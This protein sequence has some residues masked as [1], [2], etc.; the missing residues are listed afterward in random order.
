MLSDEKKKFFWNRQFN[1]KGRIVYPNLFE[2]R[3]GLNNGPKKFST[4]FMWLKEEN[5][6]VFQEMVGMIKEYK[7]KYFPKHPGFVVPFKDE[8]SKKQD[9]SD[10]PEFFDG[11]YWFNAS[12]NVDYPPKVFDVNKKEIIDPTGVH[13]GRNAII[14]VSMF[15]YEVHGKVG[16]SINLRAVVVLSGGEPVGGGGSISSGDID[17]MFADVKYDVEKEETKTV[18]GEG[19]S[20]FDS[21]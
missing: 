21:M 11:H 19:S 9:G 6:E 13:S 15:A 1:L 2:P 18:M 17:K 4:A 16:V 5:K 3:D 20:F 8:N 12:S 14:N 10:H 7:A